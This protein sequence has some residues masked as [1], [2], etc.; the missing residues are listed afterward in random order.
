MIIKDGIVKEN[1][2]NKAK[3]K[4]L[5]KNI[6]ILTVGNFSS[7]ILIFLLVPLYTNCLSAEEYGIYDL[8]ITTIQLILPIITANAAAG[9]LRFTIDVAVDN[10]VVITIWAKLFSIGCIIA[11]L[12]LLIIRFIPL[13]G[14]IHGIEVLIFGY[15]VSYAIVQSMVSYGKGLERVSTV[16]IA[17]VIS[18]VVML[19]ANIVFLLIF[20]MGIYG[21]F[22]A[23]FL[24][25]FIS[26]IYYVVTLPVIGH[27]KFSLIG[28]GK[29]CD[30]A[31]I[32][33]SD[34]ESEF[35]AYSVPLII[36]ELGW[37]I[38]HAS[39]RYVVAAFCGTAANGILSVSYKIPSIINVI[40]QIF[41]QSWHISGIKEYDESSDNSFYKSVFIYLSLVM[42]GACC[43]LILLS[44]HIGYIL[45][46]KEFFV[47]WKYTQFLLISSV[48][49]ASAGFL[50]AISAAKKD[51]RTM[52]KSGVYG[53]IVNLILNIILVW[54]IGMQGATI[55]TAI[56]SIVIFL[57][58]WRGTSEVMTFSDVSIAFASWV[59]LAVQAVFSIYEM[60]LYEIL[61]I[62]V[63]L[64]IY[65]KEI[66]SLMKQMVLVIERR[67]K[68][69]TACK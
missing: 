32:F 59:L 28:L 41:I 30:T 69:L 35:L 48:I 16:A 45:F 22:L 25:Q 63:F 27:I 24:S 14:R 29:R 49:N 18:S 50:G 37:W 53:A 61:I 67:K 26:A 5:L 58:R 40:Q 8:V 31:R 11:S 33:L 21:F 10:D 54:L 7:K 52:A 60:Y 4:N 57:V 36:V 13:F 66:L 38:N 15:F 55:A 47:A 56:S 9:L 65:R 39:D 1:K 44:K 2:D 19:L 34:I 17:G 62:A 64:L 46:A 42:T 6:G 20:H 12:G 43:L 68:S 3:F 51:S 23:S